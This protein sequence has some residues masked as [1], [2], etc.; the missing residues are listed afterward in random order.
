MIKFI[1]Y[2][3]LNQETICKIS[4][5][6]I[7]VSIGEIYIFIKTIIILLIINWIVQLL[8]LQENH[9]IELRDLNFL[10]N[11]YNNVINIWCALS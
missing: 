3:A 9:V 7:V 1:H 5:V 6:M 2:I 4:A 10:L 8:G 11:V